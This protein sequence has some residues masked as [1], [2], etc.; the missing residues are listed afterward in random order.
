MSERQETSEDMF[1][2]PPASLLRMPTVS[3][4][5]G[6]GGDGCGTDQD[7]ESEMGEGEEDTSLGL[8]SA[9]D[10]SSGAVPVG[11]NLLYLSDQVREGG[12]EG[13]RGGGRWS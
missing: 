4:D 8:I 10:A 11:S 7:A 6:V 13:G 9:M 2:L 1:R 12:R 5:E 3:E